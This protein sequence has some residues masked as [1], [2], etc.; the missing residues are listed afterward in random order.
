MPNQY[1]LAP[2]DYDPKAP[3]ETKPNVAVPLRGTGE[4]SNYD[5]SFRD[6]LVRAMAGLGEWTGMN[7]REAAQWAEHGSNLFNFMPGVGSGIALDETKRAAERGDYWNAAV[8]AVSMLPELGPIAKAGIIGT[9]AKNPEWWHAVGGGVKLR[10]PFSSLTSQLRPTGSMLEDVP[11]TAENFP[12]GSTILPLYGDR[13]M[14]GQTLTHINDAQLA[15]EQILGGGARFM[16]ENPGRIWASEQNRITNLANRVRQ[17][18]AATG[19]MPVFGAHV[20]MGIPGSDFAKMTTQPLL[21]MLQEAPITNKAARL[22]DRE[23]VSEWGINS[24]PG[25]KNVTPEWANIAP[26]GQRADLPKIMQKGEYQDLGF[27]SVAAVRKAIIDPELRDVPTLTSGMSVGR[28]APG[29]QVE[30]NPAADFLHETYPTNILGT[31]VGNMGQVPFNVMFPDFM[32]NYAA[33]NPTAMG[34]PNIARTVEMQVP[35]QRVTPQWQDS[36]MNW[37]RLNRP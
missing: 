9:A 6:Q 26:G 32:A 23:A 35:S 18:E 19:G 1:A 36:V 2:E 28:F 3:V 5:P 17:E 21:Q 29:G 4:L 22:F 24:W 33:K 30:T 16:Q 37:M 7:P 11:M 27:P 8:N 34:L 31:H 12:L 20:A 15:K 25:V 14:A 10:Q 13:T